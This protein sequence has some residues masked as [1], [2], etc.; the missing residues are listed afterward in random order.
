VIALEKE[1]QEM[2]KGSQD[3]EKEMEQLEQRLRK[4]KEDKDE[5]HKSKFAALETELQSK[6]SEISRL[7]DELTAAKVVTVEQAVV[8]RRIEEGN[9]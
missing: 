1:K 2:A 7:Q 3:K 5:E 4:E 8:P 9:A 6:A